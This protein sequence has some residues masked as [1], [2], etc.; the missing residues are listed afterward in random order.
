MNVKGAQGAQGAQGASC[1]YARETASD[2][3]FYIA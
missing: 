3:D 2:K 1:T